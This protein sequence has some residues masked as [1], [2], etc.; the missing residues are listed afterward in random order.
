MGIFLDRNGNGYGYLKI[1]ENST[2]FMLKLAIN[3]EKPFVSPSGTR[4]MCAISLSLPL[5]EMILR[6]LRFDIT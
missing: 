3:F 6:P 4:A 5:L 2:V 1:K